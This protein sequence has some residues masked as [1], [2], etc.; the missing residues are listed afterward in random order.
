MEQKHVTS[1]GV[2]IYSYEN[3]ALH[4]FC[5]SL[6][7][8][9]GPL[10]ESDREN[11]ISHF[12]EH[13][14]IRNINALMG[15][16]LYKELDLLGLSLNACTYK[17]LIQITMS[18]ATEHLSR[19]AEIFAMVF[20]DIVLNADQ[21]SVE[22]NRI[23]AEIREDDEKTS[24]DFFTNRIIWHG[25]S[26]ENT[27]TGSKSNLDS[28]G[29]KALTEAKRKFMSAE[30][31]FVY[32]TGNITPNTVSKLS[33]EIE[34][35]SIPP[36]TTVRDNSACLPSSMFKRKCVPEIKNSDIT[37]VRM[38]FDFDTSIASDAVYV[39]LFDILFEGD[40]C[41]MYQE[42]SEKTGLI[43]SYTPY[44]ERYKNVGVLSFSYEVS[45][46][47]LLES[48]KIC[49]NVLKSVKAGL[50]DELNYVIAPYT[51]NSGMLLDSPEDLNWT[52]SYEAHILEKKL[53]SIKERSA[54]FSAVT[55]NDIV[56]LANHI[57]T[58]NNMTVTLK[59][60][61]K[62]VRLDLIEEI[63]KLI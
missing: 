35:Y 9:A 33:H 36:K 42:L 3:S 49:I 28:V 1:N 55:A 11:G 61:K 56:N 41:K 8:K 18:G 13:V 20:A 44:L 54:E 12:L 43:Y 7:I 15:G 2:H 14:I 19:A 60:N 16:R 37:A 40:S 45:P 30:N 21:I 34:R 6:Y 62:T 63:I 59:G 57:F 51:I 10:Y 24:L 58:K 38:S 53:S 52:M 29:K 23:K 25:T 26:L 4:G 50:T 46:T 48:V 31:M 39:L 22:R 32:L 47:K 27:I 5:Y 17:E